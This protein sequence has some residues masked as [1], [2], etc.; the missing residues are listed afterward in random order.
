MMKQLTLELDQNY[1]LEVHQDGSSHEIKVI[2]DGQ[3]IGYATY[4]SDEVDVVYVTHL[5]LDPQHS[6]TIFSDEH[7]LA[8]VVLK[9]LLKLPQ[10]VRKQEFRFIENLPIHLEKYLTQFHFERNTIDDQLMVSRHKISMEAFTYPEGIQF[11]KY[12]TSD[13]I[14]AILQLLQKNAYWQSHLT[15]ERLHLLLKNS[16]CFLAWDNEVLVGFARVLTDN[17]T[18]AS[19]WDVVIAKEYQRR[20]IGTGLMKLIFEQESLYN[21]SN[22]I[23]F[24]DTA[25]DFY[26][27]F[28]FVPLETKPEVN[29]VYKI[30]L[31]DSQPTYMP[32]LIRTIEQPDFPTKLSHTKIMCY[33]F[34]EAGKRANLSR[35]HTDLGDTLGKTVENEHG[36][37]NQKNYSKKAAQHDTLTLN[38]T[39]YLAYR[40]INELLSR[41]LYPKIEN[42]H[43]K[44]LDFGCG[45]GLSTEIISQQIQKNTSFEVF[46]TGV[47][48]NEENLHIARKKLPH[49]DLRCIS[50]K[51]KLSDLGKFDLIICNFVLVEMPS[52]EM[53]AVLTLLQSKLSER[54]V[55]IVTN[56]TARAYRL[57]NTW[58]SFNNQ[59][60]E[61]TP[62]QKR[63]KSQKLKFVEDQPIKVEVFSSK[64]S[65]QSFTFYDFFHSGDAYRNAYHAAGLHLLETHKPIGKPEDNMEWEAEK[66][67]PPYKVHILKPS[68]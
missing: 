19:L 66:E 35:F 43:I 23:L 21:L 68:S 60:P 24:T 64:N 20:G 40:D 5:N 44:M 55:L 26:T 50:P 39:L 42:N 9:L 48:V 41:H 27:K 29:L 59:F 62:T 6:E 46:I 33:L 15:T 45:V 8:E 25:K 13:D 10:S 22:W 31:Q 49:A 63:D 61:N 38:S 3:I 37:K 67:I 7:T 47:D 65:E 12:S 1:S 2:H 36:I 11:K 16:Q 53:H 28:G 4:V 51:D 58:Y 56:P 54:G 34:G 57:E 30:R 32:D 52:D 14:P 18:F 17:K